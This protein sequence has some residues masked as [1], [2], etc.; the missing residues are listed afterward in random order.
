[1]LVRLV[2]HAT[3]CFVND[4]LIFSFA[5]GF[6]A[7]ELIVAVADVDVDGERVGGGVGGNGIDIG[8]VIDG[9]GSD[10]VDDVICRSACIEPSDDFFGDNENE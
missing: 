3:S 8:G 1:M 4:C 9:D 10:G 2:L 6:N 7:I 5:F